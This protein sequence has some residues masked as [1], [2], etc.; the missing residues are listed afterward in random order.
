[1]GS[2]FSMIGGGT[3]PE[4]ICAICT[5]AGPDEDTGLE[6]VLICPNGH[7]AHVDC[8]SLWY[9]QADKCPECRVVVRDFPLWKEIN[10]PAPAP[11]PD[12]PVLPGAPAAPA[13]A[14]P[15]PT[16]N[17]LADFDNNEGF[18]PSYDFSDHEQSI[19]AN[20]NFMNM[21]DENEYDTALEYFYSDEGEAYVKY[22]ID[23][24][25]RQ[26]SY[27]INVEDED[28]EN[29]I[30][31]S[32]MHS[33]IRDGK[34]NV[35]EALYDYARRNDLLSDLHESSG[36]IINKFADNFNYDRD[37]V[38]WLWSRGFGVGFGFL[39]TAALETKN[40][41]AVQWYLI[42]VEPSVYD[43]QLIELFDTVRSDTMD[44]QDAV[45]TV[46]QR[47]FNM[48]MQVNRVQQGQGRVQQT[49]GMWQR[50]GFFMTCS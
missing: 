44:E 37:T 5:E 40:A 21:R 18:E 35:A 14:A 24:D 2:S 30:M 12:I 25:M 1:M 33:I 43:E 15:L 9:A 17:I 3:S 16:G 31:F 10:P 28:P 49:G 29:V 8:V 6:Q 46:L 42:H 32:L 11:A 20:R 4:D 13:P 34:M 47:Y 39:E 50:G 27:L 23:E 36:A 41:D 26:Y 48:N 19:I 45:Y 22:L 7:Y 38:S